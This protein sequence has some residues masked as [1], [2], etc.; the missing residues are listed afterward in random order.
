MQEGDRECRR[1]TGNVCG[2]Q[3]VQEEGDKKFMGQTGQ[4]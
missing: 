4:N 3:E 1:E 2:R